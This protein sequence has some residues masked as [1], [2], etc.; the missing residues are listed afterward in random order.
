MKVFV[1][2]KYK[3]CVMNLL[4]FFKIDGKKYIT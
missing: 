4:I 1:I 3:A 2:V